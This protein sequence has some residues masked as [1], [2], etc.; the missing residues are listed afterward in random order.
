MSDPHEEYDDDQI[1]DWCGDVIGQHPDGRPCEIEEHQ[2]VEED[3]ATRYPDSTDPWGQHGVT[4]P[5]CGAPPGRM[6]INLR[7]GTTLP[8]RKDYSRGHPERRRLSVEQ[9]REA[10]FAAFRAAQAERP[11]P[12]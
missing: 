11:G 8:L 6:C 12:V 7:T 1:C 2:A 4:C 9:H 10:G 3:P 5:V